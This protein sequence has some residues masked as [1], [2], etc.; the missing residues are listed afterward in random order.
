MSDSRKT[1][2]KGYYI[3]AHPVTHFGEQRYL[4]LCGQ[5]HVWEQT[6][7]MPKRTKK[8]ALSEAQRELHKI[9]SGG[10]R[11]KS[12]SEQLNEKD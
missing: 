4:G 9:L 5:E 12:C 2:K 6:V 10:E 7:Y 11:I 8:E 1:T 3:E